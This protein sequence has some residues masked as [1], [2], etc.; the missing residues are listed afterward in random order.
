MSHLVSTEHLRAMLHK[1]IPRLNDKVAE[2]TGVA[3]QSTVED[4]KDRRLRL[5]LRETAERAIRELNT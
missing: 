1:N 2:P 5:S 3:N 4:E